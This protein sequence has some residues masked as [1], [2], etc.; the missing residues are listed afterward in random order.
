MKYSTQ[1]VAEILNVTDRTVRRY[2][3]TYISF[4]NNRF[5]ISEKM[6]DIL[7]NDYPGQLSD[8]TRT[9]SGQSSDDSGQQEQYD[10]IEGFTNEEYQ[11]FQKRL[12]EHP[13]LK[14][15]LEYH[16]K[17][18]ESHQRQMELI[19]NNIRERNFIEAKDKRLDN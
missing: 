6:L 7:K 11:E 16:K 15:E 4:D 14:K 18:A 2:L 8:S 5:E 19:L 10:V 9:A 3:S 13:I 17:S 1:E 12:I